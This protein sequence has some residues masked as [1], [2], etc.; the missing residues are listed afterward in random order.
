[1]KLDQK[2]LIAVDVLRKIMIEG[3]YAQLVL[4]KELSKSKL[5]QRDRAFVTQLVYMSC[6][7]WGKNLKILEHLSERPISEVDDKVKL[8][9][10]AGITEFGHMRTEPRAVVFE[11]VNIAKKITGQSSS[12]FVNAVLRG[13]QRS[14]NIDAEIENRILEKPDT[15]SEIKI[16]EFK[17]A[18]PAWIIESYRKLI[19]DIIELKTLLEMNNRAAQIHA[20]PLLTD[21]KIEQEKT[22]SSFTD[23][24]FSPHGK[25]V[26]SN[27]LESSK[28]REQKVIIQNEGSQIIELIWAATSQTFNSETS[29]KWLDLCAGPGGKAAYLYHF[30]KLKRPNDTFIANEINETRAKLVAKRMPSSQVLN[31]D[32]TEPKDFPS[33]Y[34]RILIDAPCT[35]LGAI[36]RRSESRWR[37]TE[38]ELSSLLKLQAQLLESA[39][40]LLEPGGIIGYVTCSPHML[41]TRAQIIEITHKHPDLEIL[42]ITNYLLGSGLKNIVEIENNIDRYGLQLWTHK[43]GTDSMFLSLLRKKG[44]D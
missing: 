39:Y 43:H 38:K 29:L 41:E 4:P 8:V 22:W 11:Y 5:D 20:I 30:L 44:E 25:T 35:G 7:Y 1:M 33:K 10:Q 3:A 13:Y 19:P 26:E 24:N 42:P 40:Q 12:S 31:L 32:G 2:R 14:D 21:E 34:D 28:V 16:M 37:K 9:L 17:Y 36:A 18:H 27:Y 15:K 23:L 6:R